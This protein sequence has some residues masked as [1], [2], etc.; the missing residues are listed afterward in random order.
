[1]D[2]PGTIT[3]PSTDQPSANWSR[4]LLTFPS[5]P[6]AAPHKIMLSSVSSQIPFPIFSPTRRS[7]RGE[8]SGSTLVPP[9]VCYDF[10][11]FMWAEVLFTKSAIYKIACLHQKLVE[12]VGTFRK[13][14][15]LLSVWI[16]M[17][18]SVR[19]YKV[20]MMESR[21]VYVNTS[22]G[23]YQEASMLKL[24]T[25]TV[26]EQCFVFTLCRNEYF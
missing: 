11:T 22:P 9:C 19:V 14:F 2:S 24:L 17:S 1:M 13:L 10:L 4:W 20:Q 25:F 5:N 21:C 8:V 23:K 7:F 12:R 15:V 18:L 26:L 16:W 6:A 3:P